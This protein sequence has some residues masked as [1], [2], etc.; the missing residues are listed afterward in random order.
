MFYMYLCFFFYRMSIIELSFETGDIIP[1]E[2]ESGTIR[3]D[4][5]L[6]IMP[7]KVFL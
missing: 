3:R 4:D 5:R 2:I 7:S 1:C 6:L